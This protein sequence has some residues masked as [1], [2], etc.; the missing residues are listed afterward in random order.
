M[1]T[2]TQLTIE[3]LAAYVPCGVKTLSGHYL[4]GVYAGCSDQ[5]R[6][7][8]LSET[9]NGPIDWEANFDMD[10]LIL[11]PLSQLT[12][13]I[14]HNGETFVPIK[15]ILTD[16]DYDM[17]RVFVK[18]SCVLLDCLLG[19]MTLLNCNLEYLGY[20]KAQLLLSWHFDVF[21][22]GN[23]GLCVYMNPDGTIAK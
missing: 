8:L 5:T 11:R 16:F 22:L 10:K 23:N 6:P 4:V 21:S 15:R 7:L 9:I 13:P 12:V 18:G 3:H 19:D 1:N 20:N 14:T 2:P 17:S